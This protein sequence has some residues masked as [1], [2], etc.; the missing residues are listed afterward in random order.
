MS[1][2]I[3]GL[4]FTLFI[5]VEFGQCCLWITH[6]TII[7]NL[8]QKVLYIN[9]DKNWKCKLLSMLYNIIALFK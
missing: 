6:N 1:I 3:S 9:F 2:M 7:I 8:A 4:N 5:F